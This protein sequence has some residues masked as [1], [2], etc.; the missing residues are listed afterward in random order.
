MVPAFLNAYTAMG[1]GGMSLFPAL[2]RL[3]PNW[4]V[5]YSG[6]SQLT[7]FK[8]RF[9]SVNISHAYKSVYAVGSY[10]S[11]STFVEYMGGLGFISNATTGMPQP[12]SIY[13]V[14]QVSINESFS[15]L[16]GIDVTLQNNMTLKMEYRTTRILNLAMTNAQLTE[17]TSKDLVFGFGYKIQD[18][19]PFA[20]KARKVKTGSGKDTEQNNTAAAR[21][22]RR[23][24]SHDLN[25]RLDVS[26]RKQAA[27]NR[28]IATVTSTATSGNNA[29]KLSFSADYTMSRLLTMSFYLD[30]QTNT[31]LLSSNSYPTTTQD[32]GLALKF[33]LTR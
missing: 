26:Y 29:F 19:N 22:T 7:W 31:P 8:E 14:S 12:N 3:L 17:T 33:S 10:S 30:R 25:L 13:N 21:T 4:S 9:K 27:I 32:F 23:G 5:K 1:D 18:F 6:L 11:F 15:P 16:L 20:P 24:F 28:D 2:A